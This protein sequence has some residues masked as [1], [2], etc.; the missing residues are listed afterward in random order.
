MARLELQGNE[1]APYVQ[2]KTGAIGRSGIYSWSQ[3]APSP[4][5]SLGLAVREVHWEEMHARP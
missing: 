3:N 1:P 5:S 2:S 4:L